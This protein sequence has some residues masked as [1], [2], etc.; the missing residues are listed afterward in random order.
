MRPARATGYEPAPSATPI[1]DALYAEYG[2]LFRALPGDRTGEERL[3]FE[4]F[5]IASGTGGGAPIWVEDEPGGADERPALPPG[6]GDS[7]R[8]GR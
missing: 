6:P 8:Y 3:A 1:Y 7:Q 4:G 2:R 5:G